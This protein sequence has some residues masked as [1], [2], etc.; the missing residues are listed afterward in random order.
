V[1]YCLG[2]GLPFVLA[3]VAAERFAPVQRWLMRH[4]RGVQ[5]FGG[6]LLIVIGVLLV[7]GLWQSLNTW[8]QTELVGGFEVWL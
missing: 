2:L 5:I 8:L 3:A 1:A 4:R 6:A 7:T